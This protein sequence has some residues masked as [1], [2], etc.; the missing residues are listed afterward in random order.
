MEPL[1]ADLNFALSPLTIEACCDK[2]VKETTAVHDEI[3]KLSLDDVTWQSTMQRLYRLDDK[4]APLNAS[5][6]F[7]MHVSTDASVRAASTEAT[8]RLDKLGVELSGRK[9]VY[10]RLKRLKERD[11]AKLER[12]ERR[13]LDETISDYE[14]QGVLLDGEPFAELQRIRT[15]LSALAVQFS[16]TMNE[17][18]TKLLF[19]ESELAGLPASFVAALPRVDGKCQVSLK[20][21]ELF[22]VLQNCSI[23]S[24]RQAVDEANASKCASNVALIEEAFELRR[25]A[26]RLLGYDSH[27][28]FVLEKRMAKSPQT[29]DAFLKDLSARLTTKLDAERA[30][31]LKLKAADASADKDVGVLKSFD[32]RFYQQQRL[33][34]ECVVSLGVPRH[35]LTP[36]RLQIRRRQ[37]GDQAVFSA[38]QGRRRDARALSAPLWSQV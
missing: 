27:A 20:Y 18:T 4:F 33:K 10:A 25:R 5:V 29:V 6:T 11:G 31:L 12:L 34:S 22:P 16:Q 32:W 9:D 35:N 38:R 37:R 14:R 23:A 30:A 24:T 3:G 2:I 13:L 28:A 15:R 21:T 8:A 17:D 19:A 36:P 1:P 7:P 26:A